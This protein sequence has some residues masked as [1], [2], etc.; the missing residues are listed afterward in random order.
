MP[1]TPENKTVVNG[2]LLANSVLANEVNASA[3]N[4]ITEEELNDATEGLTGNVQE[5]LDALSARME[6]PPEINKVNDIRVVKVNVPDNRGYLKILLMYDITTYWTLT[7]NKDCKRGFVGQIY[8]ARATGYMMDS[9]TTVYMGVNYQKVTTPAD[10]VLLLRT[11]DPIYRPCVV[12]NTTD[13]KYYLALQVKA[14]GRPIYMQG[15]FTGYDTWIGQWVNCTDGNG[16]LPTGY[17]MTVDQCQYIP[18]NRKCLPKATSSDIGAV[19]PDGKTVTVDAN[20]VVS[21]H[22]G[23]GI[24]IGANI[25][26]NTLT[27]PGIYKCGTNGV[28]ATLK[29]CPTS[30]AFSM[31]VYGM[32]P[33]ASVYQ[34]ITEYM[35]SGA[36][37]FFRN[38]YNNGFG[39]WIPIC[40]GVSGLPIASETKL[41]GVKPD[42]ETLEV[43]PKTGVMKVIGGVSSGAVLT[44]TPSNVV[45]AMWYEE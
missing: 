35:A 28:V 7:T 1:S 20:G 8:S 17:E 14:A 9:V 24:S 23:N 6:V 42:G 31:I 26:L 15:L 27:T 12:H 2:S 41:G 38:C 34:E 40:T 22:W 30:Y 11:D 13:N 39:A 32:C 37:K 25:D 43:D 19:K 45:G 33:P 5:Q 21:A 4:D 3:V 10:N 36:K 44:N 18:V 16:T 29:N